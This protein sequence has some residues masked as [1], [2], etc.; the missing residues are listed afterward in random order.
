MPRI[1][2][3]LPAAF[4]FST[5][6]PIYIGHIN[7]GN[8]LDNALLLTLVSEARVRFLRAM[9]YSDLDIEGVGLIIAD[10]AVQYRAEAFYGDTL[11]FSLG[12]NDFSDSGCDLV[13][14]AVDKA[15]GREVARGKSG[16]VFFDYAARCKAPVPE[17]FRE[18]AAVA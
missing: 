17:R 5:D 8:H 9:G 11:V 12:A 16:L 10:A 4:R 18:Q 14:Q 7:H 15:S 2:I 3:D 6:I 1:R 13:W